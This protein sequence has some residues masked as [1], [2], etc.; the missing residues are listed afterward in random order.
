M[1]V[2]KKAVERGCFKSN[3]IFLL[4]LKKKAWWTII[5]PMGDYMAASQLGGRPSSYCHEKKKDMDDN[6]KPV[7]S[8]N[9][10]GTTCKSIIGNKCTFFGVA[11]PILSKLLFR[12][13][14]FS[15][16]KT[17][18]SLFPSTSKRCKFYKLSKLSDNTYFFLPER[19]LCDITS[20]NQTFRF[21]ADYNQKCG[22]KEQ[23]DWKWRSDLAF[24]TEKLLCLLLPFF[25][26]SFLL[27]K[28]GKKN[29]CSKSA[30]SNPCAL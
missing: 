21:V 10:R 22:W 8:R 24:Y 18:C 27:V 1:T 20:L 2:V 26:H 17:H 5:A 19:Y 28:R 11:E 9:I 12:M 30:K 23:Y 14:F 29:R 16:Q 13:P 4:S 25:K 15:G 3:I 7:Y 6:K